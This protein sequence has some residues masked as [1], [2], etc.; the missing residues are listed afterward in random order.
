MNDDQIQD[1]KQYITAT[2][3]QATADV[4]TTGDLADMATKSDLA[5]MITK[6]DLAD[7]AAK[8][9]LI[10]MQRHINIRFDELQQ[11]IA[12]SLSVTNDS[13]DEQI[14]AH[15]LRITKLEQLTT[16]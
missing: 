4:V 6:S 10:D 1:L 15:N 13:V 2:V 12:E 3:A 16:R 14:S 7:M 9:D 5:S 11:S 8:N